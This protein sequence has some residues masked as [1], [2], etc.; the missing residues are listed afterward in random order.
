[1]CATG[2][3]ARLRPHPLAVCDRPKL[4]LA[5]LSRALGAAAERTEIERAKRKPTDSR[6][7][8]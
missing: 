2:R 7:P 3:G 1:L 8:T 4:E 5:Y 6:C